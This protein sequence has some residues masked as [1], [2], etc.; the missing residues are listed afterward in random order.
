MELI[1]YSKGH[2][3]KSSAVLASELQKRGHYV[4]RTTDPTNPRIVVNWGCGECQVPSALNSGVTTNKKTQ[5]LRLAEGGVDTV[6]VYPS[7]AEAEYP[8]LHREIYHQQGIG[9]TLVLSPEEIPAGGYLVEKL[10]II[11]EYRVHLLTLPDGSL[12]SMRVFRKQAPEGFEE[13]KHLQIRNA[14]VGYRFVRVVKYPGKITELVSLGQKA[15]GVNFGAWDVAVLDTGRIVIL[16][17]NSGPGI[18]ENAVS[19]NT[20]ADY[21]EKVL[22]GLHRAEAGNPPV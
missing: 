9:I 22:Y 11:R 16:E 13:D 12:Y 10:N 15:L 21:F 7:P 2:T 8:C 17:H 6:K 1:L 19:V 4:R 18:S 3:G 5:L 14:E 20:Y